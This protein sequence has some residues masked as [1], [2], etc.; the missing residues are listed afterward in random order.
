MKQKRKKINEIDDYMKS[1]KGPNVTKK[2]KLPLCC[3]KYNSR[4]E[5]LIKNI[6]DSLK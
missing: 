2:G 3:T 4:G 1:S 5:N 6:K